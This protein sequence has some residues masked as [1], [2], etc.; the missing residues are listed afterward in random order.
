MKTII[1]NVLAYAFLINPAL[2]SAAPAAEAQSVSKVEGILDASGVPMTIE[3]MKENLSKSGLTQAEQ[4]EVTNYLEF[5]IENQIDPSQAHAQL[6]SMLGNI[7]YTG[8]SFDGDVLLYTG[9]AL[10]LVAVLIGASGSSTSSGSSSFTWTCFADSASASAVGYGSTISRAQD[11]AL[12]NCA[13]SSFYYDT[14][15]SYAS[16]CY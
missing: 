14:C 4:E 1:C 15:Y 3:A 11:A 5:A 8:A 10:V 9:L 2:A 12:A 7:S 13:A 16:D 6:D